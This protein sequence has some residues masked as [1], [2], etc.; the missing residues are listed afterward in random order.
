MRNY[1]FMYFVVAMMT[2]FFGLFLLIAGKF[3]FVALFWAVS[4]IF[5]ITFLFVRIFEV[6]MKLE[7]NN[8]LSEKEIMKIFDE[9]FIRKK[10]KRR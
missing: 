5:S 10:K 2:F 8:K 9:H 4:I 1:T 7:E 6:L 3:E